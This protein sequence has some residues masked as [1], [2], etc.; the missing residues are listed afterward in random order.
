M[1]EPIIRL[2]N[3]TRTYHVGDVD[4]QALARRQSDHRARRIRRDHGLVRIGQVDADGDPRLSRPAEQRPLFLRGVDVAR[5]DEA[6]TGP[7][8]AA[9]GSAS[10]S[11]ASIFLART[12]AIENVALP[13]VLRRFRPGRR[14][15][16]HAS[17]RAR[18]SS[19]S[20]WPTASAI[21]RQLSGG[22]QQRVAIARALINEPEPAA[23]RR[24]DRQ[25]RHAHLARDHGDAGTLNREQGVTIVV[26]TH[27]PDIAAYADRIVTMR[28]GLIVSDERKSDSRARR[29]AARAGS[30][31]R[32]RSRRP[33]P[34]RS[35]PSTFLSFGLMII[36]AAIQAIGRNKMRSALTMLGVFIGVA[37]L[38]AMVAVGQGANDA[39]RKQIEILG[40]NLVVVLPGASTAGGVRG[41]SGSASTLTVSDAQAIRRES[42]AVGEVSYLIRQTRPDAVRQPELDHQIQGVSP[43]YPPITNW[44]IET[45]REISAD[46]ERRQPLGGRASARPCRRNCSARTRTRSARSSR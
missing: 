39:V 1:A 22:Q 18:R 14:R 19:C 37:A 10:C 5:L 34:A 16:A 17:G 33:A 42:T 3:I 45:G 41:G 15:L 26:V 35:P 8:C 38:I 32:S 36:A 20:A 7:H 11:R 23:G 12:S 46:D 21:R 31:P 24:A 9:S 43:N 29:V 25:P 40:T 6:G 2:E 28:D 13:L 44:R 27:E 30:A 4:V